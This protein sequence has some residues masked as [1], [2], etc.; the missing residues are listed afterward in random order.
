MSDKSFDSE[1]ARALARPDIDHLRA[2]LAV[3]YEWID[4]RE[5]FPDELEIWFDQGKD[6]DRG[7]A[8]VMLAAATYD[9]PDFLALVAAGLLEN[10]LQKPSNELLQRI[11]SEAR[12]TARFRW[13]L[14]VPF[15]HAIPAG[16]RSAID[17]AVGD[18]DCDGPLPPRPWA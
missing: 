10:L 2:S 6:S 5:G 17:K 7:L 14:D 8:L 16:V 11:V 1:L 3:Y 13:M 15:R 9:D 4:R 12:K 18:M